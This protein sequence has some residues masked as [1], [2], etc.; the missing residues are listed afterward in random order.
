MDGALPG[1]P[2]LALGVMATLSLLQSSQQ[3]P[4]AACGAAPVQ[5]EQGQAQP[6]SARQHSVPQQQEEQ[7]QRRQLLPVPPTEEECLPDDRAAPTHQHHHQVEGGEER[8]AAAGPST[9][10]NKRPREQADE[11]AA[12]ASSALAAPDEPAAHAPAKLSRQ[13]HH[14]ARRPAT[15]NPAS[16]AARML[17]FGGKTPLC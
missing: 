16:A 12:A 14:L 11:D 6:G 13:P 4:Q 17:R 5:A 8:A 2:F 7:E 3:Q 1:S 10:G 9:L 15:G